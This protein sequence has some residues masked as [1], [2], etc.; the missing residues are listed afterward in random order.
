MPSLVFTDQ[1]KPKQSSM[2][3]RKLHT[4]REIVIAIQSFK[5]ATVMPRYF[6]PQSFPLA[7]PL[8]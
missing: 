8:R 2:Q 6:V 7:I 5:T 1:E 3:E 4:C